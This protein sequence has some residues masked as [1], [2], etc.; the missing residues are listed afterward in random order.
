MMSRDIHDDGI[1]MRTSRFSAFCW[2]MLSNDDGGLDH[3]HHC[4]FHMEAQTVEAQEF[5]RPLQVFNC[6]FTSQFMPSNNN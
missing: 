3:K 2:V 1:R 5:Y 6:G 4:I